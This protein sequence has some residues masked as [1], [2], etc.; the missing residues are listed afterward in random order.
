LF[1]LVCE[2]VDYAHRQAIVHRDLKPSNILVKS[3]GTVRLL[4]FGIAKQLDPA[5]SPGDYTR[6]GLRLMTPAYA[7]P[8]QIRGEHSGIQTDV[9][10]LG[11]ILYELLAGRAPFDPAGLSSSEFER[12]ILDQEPPK[13][14][15]LAAPDSSLSRAAWGDLDILAQ[16]GMH[17]DTRRR[18]RSVEGLIRDLDHYSHGQPLEARPDTF[19]Y[20]AGKFVRRNRNAVA[21][22]AGVFLLLIGLV[23]FYTSRLAT[24]RNT[25]VAQAART[26]RIQDFML[27]LFNG[28]DKDA[29]PAEDLRVVTLVDH[30][31]QE[32]QSLNA[33]PA[34]QAELYHT[35]GGI[36]QKLGKLDQ[37][38]TLLRSALEQRKSLRDAG[39]G[40]VESEI[41][42]GLL[43]SDQ[44]RLDEA[45]RLVRQGLE[46]AKHLSPAN[47]AAVTNAMIAF[48]KVLEARGE[49]ARAIAALEH[50]VNAEPN[51]A[52]PTPEL[53]GLLG[54]LANNHFYAGHYDASDALNHRVL[55]MDRQLYGDRHPRVSE[56]LVNLGATQFERG[57]YAEAEKFYRQAL[58]ITQAFYGKDHYQAASGM[59]FVARAL[60]REKRF[61]EAEALL[62]QALAIQER[63]YGPVHPRVASA[64]N[65]LGAV[66]LMRDRLDTAEA[67]FR[68]MIDVYRTL[69]QDRHY[70]IGIAV[71][72]LASVYVARK[73]YAK[74]EPLYRE[75]IR[76][77]ADTLSPDHLNTGIARIKLGHTLM[78]EK[79]YAEAEVESLA[80]YHIVRRQANP[81]IAWLDDARRDLRAIYA[82]LNEPDKTELLDHGQ[83]AAR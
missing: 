66:A 19:G 3:D 21:A 54:E 26:Q 68:R 69:Y 70:L 49:Y 46:D 14:S 45:E 61:D 28:G 67:D 82:G 65:E 24:A 52:K 62:E 25:A 16:T 39:A 11:V 35:L 10:A 20:R 7:A 56:D 23:T 2:A 76:R 80:G 57:N 63:V 29:G 6:T 33:E 13:P 12:M 74:A 5:D 58:D 43:R 50:A 75:A 31:V 17:K 15:A 73:Q 71:S 55:E 47:H 9:Y 18:Y 30:G 8:E 83:P 77:F 48:G 78:R 53:A 64:L 42:L 36:Y 79:K 27:N 51:T 4:D 38:D 32:A 41:A 37:A 34:V 72:N 44:T 81:S 60:V 22:S 59:T 1:R 40:L